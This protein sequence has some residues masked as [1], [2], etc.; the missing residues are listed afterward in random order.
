MTRDTSLEFITI[1]TVIARFVRFPLT[2]AKAARIP[3][4]D[5]GQCART[6]KGIGGGEG[7]AT[8]LKSMS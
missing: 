5:G 1:E 7:I 8:I 4:R 3:K 6:A 2:F